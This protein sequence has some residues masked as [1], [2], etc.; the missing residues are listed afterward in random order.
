M[1]TLQAQ[2]ST[3]LT[4]GAESPPKKA[5]ARQFL[6][7]P[8]IIYLIVLTQL[9][10]VFVLTY[11]LSNWN[12]LR[13]DRTRFV[14][15]Q[16]YGDFFTN[17]DML[18]ILRNTLVFST[19][20]VIFSLV[21]GM[22]LALMLN[23]QFVGRGIARTLLITPFLIMPTVSAV[24]WKNMLFNPSFGLISTTLVSF[25]GPRIDWIN[26]YPMFSIVAI[27]VWEWTPFMMLILLAGLQSLPQEYV[28][29]AQI[30]GAG[31]GQIF[32][33][34]ILPHLRRYIEIGVLLEVLFVLNIFGEIFVTTT[35]GPAIDTTTLGFDIYK[36][37]FLRWNIGR[38][39]AYGVFAVILANIVTLI[40]L[41]VIRNGSQKSRGA[42]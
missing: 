5:N 16:N 14:G 11:S 34:I 2:P 31:R 39:S 29:A 10:L 38:S 42:A 25:G 22:L 6:L 4:A 20:V 36:E 28:E 41:R 35:G 26:T 18:T 17:P 37:A 7:R 40:F 32:L 30:D 8:A 9:P 24:M 3:R 23:R 27:V 19:S 21:F 15:L 33:N 12:L 13:P 1:S